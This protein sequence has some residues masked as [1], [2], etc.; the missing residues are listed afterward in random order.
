MP[1]TPHISNNTG[2]RWEVCPTPGCDGSGNVVGTYSS[3]RSLSG[4]PRATAAM[5]RAKLSSE[6][7]LEIHKKARNGID[8][9]KDIDLKSLD[10]DIRSLAEENEQLTAGFDRVQEEMKQNEIELMKKLRENR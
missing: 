6:V 9:N 5:K 8:L 2:P 3:H 1:L 7:M 10:D 4:C